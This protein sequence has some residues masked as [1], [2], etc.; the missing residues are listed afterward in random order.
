MN[1]DIGM[2]LREKLIEISGYGKAGALIKEKERDEGDN[3]ED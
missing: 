1:L 2:G 3:D